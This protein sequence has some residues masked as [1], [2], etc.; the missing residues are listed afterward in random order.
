MK[1]IPADTTIDAAAKQIE[2]L[3]RLDINGR[4]QMTFQLS[5]NLRR[6]VE[7]GV[8]YRHPD[9]DEQAVERQVLRLMIGERLFKQVS[10]ETG[11]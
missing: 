6:I 9:F 11:I 1:T 5:N 2:V 3:R 8:R 4:A 10:G 7:A